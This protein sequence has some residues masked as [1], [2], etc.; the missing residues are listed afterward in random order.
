MRSNPSVEDVVLYHFPPSLCSQK[1][2]VVLE[3]KGVGYTSKLVNIGP[4]MENYEPWYAR[5]NPGLVVPTLVVSEEAITNSA[6]IVAEIDA[7]F[8]GPDLKAGDPD[9]QRWVALQDG[10][11][12]RE[13][14]Y[15]PQR[16]L[17]G[18]LTKGS[19]EKRRTI[20]E[21]NRTEH[22][23]LA[24]LYEAR[25]RDVAT[26]KETSFSEDEVARL[27]AAVLDALAQVEGRLHDGEFLAGD[28]YTLA[29]AVWTVMLARCK[30]MGF[31]KS[32]GPATA[33]YYQRMKQRPSFETGDVWERPKP[34]VMLPLIWGVIKVNLGLAR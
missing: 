14:G 27:R 11:K 8:D 34:R 15:A 23:E 26:W 4:P 33:A 5:L 24:H 16:G 19:F 10:L 2:R 21:R 7:R 28:T 20:L 17:L 22:P 13:I 12:I 32:W 6:R 1:V 31:A 3:E 30:F 18:W 25:L 9:V 29:D